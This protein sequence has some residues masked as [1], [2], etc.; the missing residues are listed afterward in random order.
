MIQ[1][2]LTVFAIVYLWNAI[3]ALREYIRFIKCG[4]KLRAYIRKYEFD[5]P[6]AVNDDTY[7]PN[8]L[9][10]L[11]KYRPFIQRYIDDP[12]LHKNAG[13]YDIFN[14]SKILYDYFSDNSDFKRYEMYK[15][16][17]P[18]KTISIIFSFPYNLLMKIGINIDENKQK[19]VNIIGT[20][21][22]CIISYMVNGLCSELIT[23]LKLIFNYFINQ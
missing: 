7:Y 16:F 20:I 13:A 14:T 2:I 21:I 1:I 3:C 12:L 9:K 15:S 5:K 22:E 11:L 10:K 6:G 4:Y 8:E 18:V 23:R 17:N 19:H